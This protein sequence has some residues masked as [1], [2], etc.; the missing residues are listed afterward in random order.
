[1]RNVYIVRLAGAVKCETTAPFSGRESTHLYV[2]ASCFEKA[3]EAVQR[4]YP[5]CQIR[6]IDLANY[7]GV[8]VVAGD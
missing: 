4:K 5:G 1:M 6:G 2:T 3:I 8:P 7:A